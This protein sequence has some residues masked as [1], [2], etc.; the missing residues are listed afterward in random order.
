MIYLIDG[1]ELSFYPGL[2]AEDPAEGF[3]TGQILDGKFV[4]GQFVTLDNKNNR[5][6]VPGD[7]VQNSKGKEVVYLNG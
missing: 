6:F 2:D 4:P 7:M 3:I 1:C 5:T